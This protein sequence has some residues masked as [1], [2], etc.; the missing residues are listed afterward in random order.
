ML[1]LSVRTAD[2]GA[3][4]R[5]PNARKATPQTDGVLIWALT[6]RSFTRMLVTTLLGSSAPSLSPFLANAP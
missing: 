5:P 1:H 2:S 6:L 3:H 4:F